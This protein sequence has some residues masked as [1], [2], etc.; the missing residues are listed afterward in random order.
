MKRPDLDPL[1]WV[2]PACQRLRHA[3]QGNLGI[4]K[5]Y[6]HDHIRRLRCRTGGEEFSE[7][8][9][10]ALFNTK[11]PEA[12]A[13]DVINHLGEGCSVRATACLVKVWK[14]TVTRLL[15]VSGR[16]AE[17]WHDPQRIVH[18]VEGGLQPEREQDDARNHRQ[19]Q[20]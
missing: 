1:A 13:E 19:V 2:N 5:V 9:G 4:R 18:V 11:L 17:R 8:R 20:V 12:K 6:G 7:R 10:R 3:G 16:Q 14:E 15:R